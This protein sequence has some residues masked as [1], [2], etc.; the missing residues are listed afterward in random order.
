M[1]VSGI[2]GMGLSGGYFREN[3]QFIEPL[4]YFL[5]CVLLTVFL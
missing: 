4:I 5:G 3:E 2:G 1:D